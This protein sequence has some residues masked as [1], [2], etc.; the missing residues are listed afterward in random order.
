MPEKAR[1][2]R[3]KQGGINY[4]GSYPALPVAG[5]W[6]PSGTLSR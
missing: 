4:S 1:R 3:K 2:C 5:A 6:K